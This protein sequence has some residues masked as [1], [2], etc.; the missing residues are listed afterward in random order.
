M[1][2]GITPRVCTRAAQQLP[3]GNEA[4][5]F[6]TVGCSSARKRCR[7]ADSRWGRGTVPRPST[8]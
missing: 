6:V 4:T 1:S 2:D 3:H 7:S 5:P 8:P